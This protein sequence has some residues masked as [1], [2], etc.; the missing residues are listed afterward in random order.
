MHSAQLTPAAGHGHALVLFSSLISVIVV[1]TVAIFIFI[2]AAL[3][4]ALKP[5]LE[6]PTPQS[7]T[8]QSF[9]M[10]D[11]QLI[12]L[13]VFEQCFN[14]SKK[15]ASPWL[16]IM[17]LYSLLLHFCFMGHELEQQFQSFS[18]S[19]STRIWDYNEKLWHR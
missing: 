4:V 8:K 11:Q 3:N 16:S 14:T 9:Q 10:L 18:S 17:T 6:A 15:K 2:T 12:L 19:N 13:D 5:L 7:K 1:L